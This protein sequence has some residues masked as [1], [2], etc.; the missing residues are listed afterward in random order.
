L[1]RHNLGVQGN[2]TFRF[3][4]QLES[5]GVTSASD[6]RL[7]MSFTSGVGKLNSGF[8]KLNSTLQSPKTTEVNIFHINKV[9]CKFNIFIL[10][11]VLVFVSFALFV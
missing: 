10:R 5:Q 7:Y 6:T 3:V 8:G 11:Q 4:D 1:L 2:Q 9:T